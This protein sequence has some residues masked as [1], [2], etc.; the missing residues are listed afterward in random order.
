MHVGSFI[1]GKYRL[2]HPLG[3]GAMGVVWAAVNTATE[4]RVAVK[5][6]VSALAGNEEGRARLLRE[7]RACGR[8]S[9]RNVIEVLDAGEP[10]D[11][12]PFV[13][14]PLLVGETL[15]SRL[16]RSGPLA[17][18]AAAMIALDIARGLAAA[19][20]AGIVHRDLK[21]GNVFL[22]RE[23]DTGEET[24]KLL[25]FGV[26]K[27]AGAADAAATATGSA[28]GSP[29]YMAPEQVRGARDI[30]HRADLWALGVLLYELISGARPFTGESVYAVAGEILSGRIPDV[31][32]HVPSTD[33]RLAAI[34][35][36]CLERDLQRR[37]ATA[38]EIAES[39]RAYLGVPAAAVS[40][41][42][43]AY[44]DRTRVMQRQVRHVPSITSTTPVL[45]G[46][47]LIPPSHPAPFPR[48]AAIAAISVAGLLLIIGTAAFL[49]TRRAP[50][51]ATLAP[52]EPAVATRPAVS[53]APQVPRVVVQAT[54]IEEL[55][56]PTVSAAKPA[57]TIPEV[58]NT[59]RRASARSIETRTP[60]ARPAPSAATSAAP[61]PKTPLPTDPG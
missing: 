33:P 11:G 17:E 41:P 27:V 59:S 32:E 54:P 53:V 28:L 1:A 6:M 2:E 52:A 36:S 45:S 61:K 48:R 55:P 13:V 23:S 58:V 18:R 30:D 10:E 29:A 19:H 5:V 43:V 49:T 16:D 60:L 56:R 9:H 3:E 38:G 15:A 12:A 34:I 44:D 46:G 51:Q 26:S 40:G 21:P 39:L 47:A 20:A 7:A 35:A 31:R 14:M 25:D 8:I 4:R 50:S 22:V 37:V 57:A 42:V 24:V